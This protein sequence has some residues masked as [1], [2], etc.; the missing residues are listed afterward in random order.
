M[1][2]LQQIGTGIGIH[3]SHAEYMLAYADAIMLIPDG[4]AD[5]QGLK[6]AIGYQKGDNNFYQE[7][8]NTNRCNCN[9]GNLG[10]TY[11]IQ[12]SLSRFRKS[13]LFGT[14]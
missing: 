5:E 8:S 9:R 10:S 6:T 14:G 2:L 13:Q 3:G 1:F 4:L 12:H 11:I 7:G